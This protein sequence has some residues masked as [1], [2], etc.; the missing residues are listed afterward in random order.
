[1]AIRI[2]ESMRGV[3]VWLGLAPDESVPSSPPSLSLV[4]PP[5]TCTRPL[6][7]AEALITPGPPRS[8]GPP[9][10]A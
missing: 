4:P 9:W 7:R 10:A 2:E 8:P 6:Q 3:M 1:M 5:V